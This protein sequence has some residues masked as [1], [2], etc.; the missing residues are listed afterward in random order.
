MRSREEIRLMVRVARMYHTEGRAQPDIASTLGLSQA[1]VSRLLKR[2]EAEGIVRITV[3]APAGIHTDLEDA[4][5]AAFKLQLAIVV[6]APREED[7]LLAELGAAAAFYI[8]TTLRSGDVVG[9][10]S[11]SSSLLAT[12][13][14]LH[15]VSKLSGVRMVQVLGGV[16]DPGARVHANRLTQRFAQLVS[17]EPVFLPSPGLAGSVASA[18]A[19][20]DD[21][22]VSGTMALFDELTVAFVGIGALEPSRLLASSGNAF[23]EFELQALK[24]DA[25]AV[26]DI[27]LRFFDS[28]GL[29]VGG[30][31][32]DRVIG[33][34]LDQLKATGRCVAVAGGS[35][36][37]EAIRAALKG[38]W[39]HVLI[40]DR[41]TAQRVLESRRPASATP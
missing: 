34:T 38:G 5:V 26:G 6:D 30:R 16:G 33:I 32:D 7:Y 11:W 18:K 35:R 17:G 14:A 1:K 3:S 20:R 19:L 22:Y 37:V 13:D 36:K 24:R 9:I 15:P 27:G 10:S 4:L 8:E 28:D 39:V 2:A 12:A 41:A 21:P 23:S 29:P 31:F 25:G 40:T